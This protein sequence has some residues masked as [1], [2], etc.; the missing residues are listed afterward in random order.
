MNES[1]QEPPP[2]PPQPANTTSPAATQGSVT[3]TA[4]GA[5]A[6]SKVN[7]ASNSQESSSSS[8]SSSD[9]D[10]S[11]TLLEFC[12]KVVTG[13]MQL[14]EWRRGEEAPTATVRA[15]RLGNRLKETRRF[16]LL[17]QI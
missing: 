16:L 12:C 2:P 5:D 4:D 14:G 6:G 1:R 7:N 17:I 8:S 3:G 15:E 10:D 13:V 11:L 9:S